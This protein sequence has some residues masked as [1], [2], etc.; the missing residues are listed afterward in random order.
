[1]DKFNVSKSSKCLHSYIVKNVL[2]FNNLLKDLCLM[3]NCVFLDCFS[4]FL[5]RDFRS[6]HSEL[7]HDWLY[8]N[9]M[10]VVGLLSTWLNIV[11]NEHS[12][13]MV[14]NNLLGI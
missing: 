5:T 12:F 8:L 7:Y 13:D 14:V 1:M 10:K 3:N 4:D 6:C 11:V 2:D 9:I